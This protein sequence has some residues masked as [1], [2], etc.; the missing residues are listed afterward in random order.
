MSVSDTQVSKVS[1]I[2]RRLFSEGVRTV[3]GQPVLFLPQQ[4]SS[5]RLS[6]RPDLNWFRPTSL[7]SALAISPVSLPVPVDGC[8]EGGDEITNLY[9]LYLAHLEISLCWTNVDRF[10]YYSCIKLCITNV[11]Q[12]C[13][14]YQNNVSNQEVSWSIFL[15]E[16]YTKVQINIHKMVYTST[17]VYNIKAAL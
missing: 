13:T 2:G 15:Y 5:T 17:L 14:G 3:T 6:L 8:M 16:R 1:Q 11:M 4:R 12:S 7:H 9:P 10:Y